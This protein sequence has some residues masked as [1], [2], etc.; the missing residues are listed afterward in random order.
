MQTGQET[1]S[2][3]AT[4]SKAQPEGVD[5]G[6][7]KEGARE[8]GQDEAKDKASEEGARKKE[9]DAVKNKA[10]EGRLDPT[11]AWTTGVAQR[12]GLGK[13]ASEY[14]RPSPGDPP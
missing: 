3:G 2:A 11:N 4:S 10:P 7:A 13:P 5:Q 9:Q 12:E 14:I 8:K 1:E 6:K